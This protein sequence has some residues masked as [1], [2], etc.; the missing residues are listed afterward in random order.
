[1]DEIQRIFSMVMRQDGSAKSY[2]EA[3]EREALDLKAAYRTV[4]RIYR[5][6]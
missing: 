3:K 5:G 2:V 6:Y 4:N 1:M